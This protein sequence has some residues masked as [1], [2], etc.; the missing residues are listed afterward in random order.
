MVDKSKSFEEALHAFDKNTYSE[1]IREAGE[2]REKVV[3]LFPLDH[4][5]D[6][7]LEEYALGQESS[8]NT[9]CRWM[10]FRT[11]HLGS[12]R[13]GSAAK[14][15]IYKHKN[16]PGWYFDE[17]KYE[18]VQQAWEAVRQGFIEALEKASQDTWDEIDD[19]EAIRPGPA[20]R[21][22]TLY[23]Y[24]PEQLI[25]V[26]SRQHIVHF[27]QK[28]EHPT[29]GDK[30][31]EVVRLNRALL[32][33]LR[34][35]PKLA[36]WPTKEL[37]RFL[38]FWAD[39][40]EAKQVIK[41]APGENARFWQDCLE[42]GYMCVGWDDVG[43]L[44][45]FESKESFRNRFAEEFG[46]SYGHNQGQITRKANELWR[47]TDLETGDIV[48]AN[49]GIRKVLALGEV[50]EP[51]YEWM[52]EREEYK[53]IVRI[54]WDTSYAQEIP[55][56]KSWGLVTV[57]PVPSTLYA[58]IAKHADSQIVQIPVDPI[59]PDIAEALVR[60][61]QAI[62][63]GPPGTG[64][65]YTACRFAVWWLLREL[66]EENPPA[67]LADSNALGEAERRLSTG[68]MGGRVWWVVANPK[69][70]DWDI[71][72]KQGKEQFSFGRLQRNY[73]QV[74]ENDLVI[75]YQA[76]PDKKIMALARISRGLYTDESGNKRIDLE[77]VARV[78][79]GLTYE[80][81][82]GD[83]ILSSAEPMRHR[84][85]GTLFSLTKN[86]AEYLVALLI[87]RNPDIEEKIDLQ[88]KPGHLT[89]LTFHASY[90]YEDFI[91]GFRP[92]DTGGERLVLTLEDGVLKR[93]CRQ[94]Q[95]N[96]EQP[97]LILIDEI[98]RAN[99]AKVFGELI[100]LLEK[101]KRGLAV[102]LPQ[103]KE[104]FTIP[105]NVYFLVLL[106]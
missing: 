71:L 38:Y 66:G 18:N 23:I 95:A 59:F 30:T 60:K 85:Q 50:I 26:F 36:D 1:A 39:P 80:E 99:I 40:R 87:E 24:F 42:G 37:E 7:T 16:R 64:K 52:P 27:L 69:Q 98:N 45:D 5:S 46:A 3:K 88:E 97:F 56:Q 61:R 9:Y 14:M 96:P 74:Q 11:V 49:Q 92:V 48:V 29:G 43:D 58:Q 2:Q 25:P 47:L 83:S 51:G 73:S 19:I 65:T 106:C 33:A 35:V 90:S 17:Q 34:A 70:W 81:L 57:A 20:L 41:I 28:L 72:F 32:H 4:W 75:G 31:Y 68:Q 102:T 55:A 77:P 104:I 91:E 44:R 84:N 76:H 15:I 12:I 54:N 89:R 93:I 86:E 82:S 79:N 103:S 101:D 13:G 6:M 53:H 67:I 105:P 94:A 62:L 8:E 100:T 78:E 10:E 21:L 22:K 63:Y